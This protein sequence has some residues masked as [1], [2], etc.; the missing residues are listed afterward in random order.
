MNDLGSNVMHRLRRRR[1]LTVAA[2]VIV[3]ERVV[4]DQGGCYRAR[5]MIWLDI[6]GADFEFRE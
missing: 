1:W 6:T 4:M 5:T 3:L 2:A